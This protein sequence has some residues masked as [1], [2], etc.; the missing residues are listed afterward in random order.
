MGGEMDSCDWAKVEGFGRWELD[1]YTR[2]MDWE[3]QFQ[4]EKWMQP[5][6]NYGLISIILQLP[7][8]H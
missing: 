3:N 2:K 4:V 6:Y 5:N 1:I 8:C 7:E